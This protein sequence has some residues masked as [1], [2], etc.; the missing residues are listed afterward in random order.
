M[1]HTIPD[2]FV[3]FGL[4]LTD[5]S[6]EKLMK[7]ANDLFHNEMT[8]ATNIY[9]DHITLLHKNDVHVEMIKLRMYDL[10]NHIFENH[11]GMTYEVKVIS[12]GFNNRA[13]AFGVELPGCFPVFIFKKYHIT[14][15]TFSNAKPFESNK[16]TRWHKLTE[17][18]TI[19]TA[20]TKVVATD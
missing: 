10:L 4:F 11:I 2:D 15:G 7:V 9:L 20:L 5:E 16:I 17:P 18:I 8:I 6:K 12:Y 13:F 19:T 14:I 3:Y 1:I